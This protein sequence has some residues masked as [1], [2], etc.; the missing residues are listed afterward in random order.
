[1]NGGATARFFLNMGKQIG[2][3]HKARNTQDADITIA[4][5]PG[6]A[7][8]AIS[9]K[10]LDIY[11]IHPIWVNP[12]GNSS[13]SASGVATTKL[14]PF[15][16]DGHIVRMFSYGAGGTATIFDAVVGNSH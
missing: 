14:L 13:A 1:M 16:R 4:H 7:V 5:Q 12:E 9:E 6:I 10:L 8:H 15:F 2:A 11:G 3:G